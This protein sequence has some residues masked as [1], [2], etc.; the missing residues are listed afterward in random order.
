MAYQACAY[1]RE[2]DRGRCAGIELIRPATNSSFKTLNGTVWYR[3]DHFFSPWSWFEVFI[4]TPAGELIEANCHARLNCSKQLLNDV[5]FIRFSDKKLFTLAILKNS[6]NDRL[7][8]TSQQN[9][10]FAQ[11]D[12]DRGVA[13]R[14]CRN[15]A[16]PVW[17]TSIWEMGIKVD[18]TYYY[19]MLLSQ[20]LL[21]AIRQVSRVPWQN[22]DW[23]NRD[24]QN[25]DRQKP[26]PMNSHL[27]VH[28]SAELFW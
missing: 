27:P 21:P 5:I 28:P 24:R 12:S 19:D 15:L 7:I 25:R 8:M 16:T 22:R 23:Q 3:T 1:W 9:A 11:T 20:Q 14:T 26:G 17:Y 4:E 10:V 18:G 13:E 2:C 6:Q